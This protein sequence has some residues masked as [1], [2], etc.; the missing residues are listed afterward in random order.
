M[1]TKLTFYNMVISLISQFLFL[2]LSI[3]FPRLIILVFGSEVNG[4]T[5]SINQILNIIN[6][7]QAGVVGASIYDMYKPIAEKDDKL[8]AKIFYSSKKYF[9]KLSTIFLISGIVIIPFFLLNSNNSISFIEMFLSVVILTLNGALIFKYVSSYDIIISAH[10]R[11]YVLVYSSLIEKIIYYCLL[12]IVLY[13]KVHFI[14]MY[15]A[16]IC[17]TIGR[18]IFLKNYFNKNYNDKINRYSIE[19]NYK[20]KNQYYLLSNQ[21]IQQIIESA[22]TLIISSF[23]GLVTTSV[24]SLYNMIDSA[25]KM[26]FTTIQN[27]I[28]ASF[29]DL[30]TS[31]KSHAR[32]IF[33]ITHLLFLNMGQVTSS[34]M[35]VLCIPFIKLYS[36][37]I[38]DV[39]YTNTFLAISMC[40][41]SLSY[42]IFMPYNM[43]I[44]TNGEYKSVTKQ[45]LIYGMIFIVL[46]LIFSLFDYVYCIIL[47]ALFYIVSSIDRINIIDKKIFQLNKVSHFKRIL[48]SM[49][50]T[51]IY[52]L[53]F[54]DL[55]INSW[56]NFIGYGLFHLIITSILVIIQDFM[57]DRRTM[58]L[59]FNFI[60]ERI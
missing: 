52:Y 60:K 33:D 37:G 21:I 38:T 58:S 24:F 43:A 18:I 23:Y 22:P 10:Q 45:N 48:L 4:L 47:F 34:C 16:L 25:F 30:S 5:S 39:N 59:L 53:I 9:S 46:A 26:I 20:I 51:F 44:N 27:S 19:T 49:L 50:V 57:F 11:K 7:L 35:M 31:N 8:L 42:C 6:L 36:S 32:D 2:I 13:F 3:I 14:L 17:G 41:L 54:K 1:R 55:T 15:L 12:L 28:A 56:F 29:G 40:M